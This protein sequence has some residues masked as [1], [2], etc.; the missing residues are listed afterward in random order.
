MAKTL[1]QVGTA[2]PKA[3]ARAAELL[4]Q[5]DLPKTLRQLCLIAFS[6]DQQQR[7]NLACGF[8]YGYLAQLLDGPTAGL[9]GTNRNVLLEMNLDVK[10]SGDVI[11]GSF[12]CE[13][14]WQR[15][16]DHCVDVTCFLRS[17]A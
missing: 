8:G 7:V 6:G 3:L 12:G 13:A 14:V 5:F 1:L 4:T 16:C 17:V 15:V 9:D 10:A 11:I 2:C